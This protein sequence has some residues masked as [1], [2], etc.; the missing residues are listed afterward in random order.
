VKSN[1]PCKS[2]ILIKLFVRFVGWL[3]FMNE[4]CYLLIILWEKR[5]KIYYIRARERIQL[6]V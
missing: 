2:A 3:L 1:T 4:T 6:G 5:E